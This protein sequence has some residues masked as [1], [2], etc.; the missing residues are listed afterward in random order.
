MD[1]RRLYN[2]DTILYKG[3]EHLCILVFMGILESV[4]CVLVPGTVVC[5]M[6]AFP[7]YFID[8]EYSCYN[9]ES[10][11]PLCILFTSITDSMDMTL[12][13]FWETEKDREAWY[14][15]VHGVTKSQ[16]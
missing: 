16:T 13:K 7:E 3:L 4:S 11:S 6:Y 10:I 15:A 1:V 9:I 5:R 8:S 12:S 14:A 2:Y